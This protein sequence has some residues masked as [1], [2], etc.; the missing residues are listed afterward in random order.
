ML[1]R[2]KAHGNAETLIYY[3]VSP[4]VV[5]MFDDLGWER[6]ELRIERNLLDLR[7]YRL[8]FYSGATEK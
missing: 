8:L 1:D 7:K 3:G 6:S 4:E 2:I 5:A